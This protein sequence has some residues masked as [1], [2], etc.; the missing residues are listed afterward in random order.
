M[1]QHHI[2]GNTDSFNIQDSFNNLWNNC[3]VANEDSEILAW[4][5]PLEP[6]LRHYDI[7]TRRVDEVGDWLLKPMN[8]GIGLVAFMVVDI[9]VQPYF[10]MEVRGLARLTLGIYEGEYSKIE[11]CC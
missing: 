7:R 11:K 4:I 5:S 3:T 1:S 9:M 8:I 2:S 6:Q 10:V